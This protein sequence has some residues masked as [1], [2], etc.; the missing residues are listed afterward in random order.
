MTRNRRYGRR[1]YRQIQADRRVMIE[2]VLAR[3]RSQRN[4][5]CWRHRLEGLTLPY[6]MAEFLYEKALELLP[7]LTPEERLAAWLPKSVRRSWRLKSSLRDCALRRL[8]PI[9]NGYGGNP[10]L[11]RSQEPGGSDNGRPLRHS[12]N[13]VSSVLPSG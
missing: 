12:I 9:S 8:K 2:G 1:Q 6:T 4:G 13:A 3:I 10:T 7:E 11:R 5:Y